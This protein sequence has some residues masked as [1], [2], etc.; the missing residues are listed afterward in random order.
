[1]KVLKTT[2]GQQFRYAPQNT[3]GPAKKAPKK[4]QTKKMNYTQ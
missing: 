4:Y 3:V 2:I 1:M